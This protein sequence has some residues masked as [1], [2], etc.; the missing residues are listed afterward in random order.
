MDLKDIGRILWKNALLILL[1]IFIAGGGIY[2]YSILQAPIF[3]SIALLLLTTPTPKEGSMY[4]EVLTMERQAKTFAEMLRS[5]PIL[6]AVSP[7]V[8][9]SPYELSL[10]LGVTPLVDTQLIQVTYTNTSPMHAQ[11]TLNAICDYFSQ[12]IGDLYYGSGNNIVQ[13]L[14][15]QVQQSQTDLDSAKRALNALISPTQAQLQVAQERVTFL[16]AAYLDL[17]GKLDTA[18]QTQSAGV[19]QVIVYQRAT[20]P[21]SKIAPRVTINVAIAVLFGLFLGVALAFL[22]NYLDDTL[23]TEEDVR[24]Y[25][26]GLPVLGAIPMIPGNH[27]RSAWER[28]KAKD[29]ATVAV[30]KD[31]K[32]GAAEG[33]RTLRT[34]L[35]FLS[36]NP[37]F[38]SLVITSPTP[39]EG[40]STI[41]VNLATS[42]AQVGQ[43]VV[44]I[45]ADLRRP[46]LHYTFSRRMSPGL[47]NYLV[48]KADLTSILQE[49][50]VPNLKLIASGTLPPMPAELLASVRMQVLLA[51]LAGQT[52]MVI[53]DSPPAIAVTDAAILAT[54]VDGV[55]MV[56]T[57][58]STTRDQARTAMQA[59]ENAG[60]KPL[61]VV[62]NQ[63][64]RRKGYGY[65]YFYYRRYY[66]SVQG[67]TDTTAGGMANE[68][69]SA[70][71][72]IFPQPASIR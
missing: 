70:E 45:D 55:V 25:M 56:I 69:S 2:Y 24:K 31:P 22:R 11:R 14:E 62:M 15:D 42:M 41:A 8:D 47:S 5:K 38:R 1:V 50:T 54:Q 16:Q 3:Q 4:Q 30:A 40:K 9:L 65:Y 57:C 53:I 59:L 60:S 10:N 7:S 48:G 27:R 34:N 49:T 67:K 43:R 28:S 39:A 29:H 44:L 19:S 66:P 18:R 6:E 51:E 32:S 36:V 17:V 71:G 26:R 23:K 58:G 72:E 52:E 20:L 12:Y 35:Q 46:S 63:V 61:G 37:S 33:F 21:Q 68:T 13:A 64:D